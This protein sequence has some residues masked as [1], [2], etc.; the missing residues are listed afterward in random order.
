VFLFEDIRPTPFV[1]F[2]CR[3]KKCTSAIMVT[4]SHNPSNYN[5]YKVYWNDG[6]QILPPHDAKIIDQ[7]NQINDP[8]Q[9]K[10]IKD[11]H[12]PLIEWVGSG[13]DEAYFQAIAPLQNY[14]RSNQQEGGTLKV[15]YTSLH[16]TGIT[17]M[18]QAL[19]S[20]GFTNLTLVEDQVIPDGHFPTAPYPN[21]EEKAALELGIK[22]LQEMQGDI[23]IATD[24]DAD[25]VGVVVMH[26]RRP[27]ILT[28]NQI[29]SLC[30]D[31]ICQVLIH[32]G[33][34]PERGAFV[35]SIVTTE[36]FQAI[37]DFYQKPSFNV[38]TGFKYIA[39]K[40]R[41][42]EKDSKNGFQFVFGGEESYGYLLGTQVRDKDAVVM[43]CLICEMAL[44]A[45]KERKTLVDFLE[46]LYHKHG[47]FVET[48]LSIQF[49]ES[50]EGKEKMAQGIAKLQYAPP[51]HLNGIPVA[52][53]ENYQTAIK[54]DLKT[55]KAQPI[56]L[57]RSDML[58]FWLEDQ[59]KVV[60]R[61]SGT[62]PKIK[63]YC[64]VREVPGSSIE[65]AIQ[66]A[67]EKAAKLVESLKKHL[68][69]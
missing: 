21:P 36:L 54:T 6:G 56:D 33:R 67:E 41:E 42:W 57:P 55:G 38:L 15:V 31:H 3:Y 13:I 7:V 9:V 37:A 44:R 48:L 24:P 34:M 25:R 26:H 40:I 39:Q 58:I 18:P 62:E 19:S 66:K 10:T 46:E 51:S 52:T 49:E 28:G 59:S 23:L 35:K 30:L 17:V 4:A 68:S 29:A 11:L 61:P 65:V 53:L 22:K 43:S 32:D 20:W 45:K 47:V 63:I 69:T 2:G 5:G 50:K 1:S 16:G 27:R 60:I 64:G 12:H 8:S 14:L